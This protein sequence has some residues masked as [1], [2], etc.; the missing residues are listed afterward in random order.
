MGT[1]G[2]FGKY[3]EFLSWSAVG[4]SSGTQRFFHASHGAWRKKEQCV[5]HLIFLGPPPNPDTQLLLATTVPYDGNARSYFHESD[6]VATS[7]DQDL[8]ASYCYTATV[9]KALTHTVGDGVS[10]NFKIIF[11]R[12]D[13]VRGIAF[14]AGGAAGS[15]NGFAGSLRIPY[16]INVESIRATQ[17]SASLNGANVTSIT[18]VWPPYLKAVHLAQISHLTSIAT[19]F[20]KTLKYLELSATTSLGPSINALLADCDNMEILNLGS[21]VYSETGV[22]GSIFLGAINLAISHMTNIKVFNIGGATTMTNITFSNFTGVRRFQ[23]IAA[24]AMN[25]TTL[26]AIFNDVFISPV[27][28]FFNGRSSNLVWARSFTNADFAATLTDFYFHANQITGTITLTNPKPSLLNFMMGDNGASFADALKN[29][30]S[31]VDLSGLTNALLI[32]I[33]NC[34]IVNLT[35]PVNTVCTILGLGGNNLSV[36]TNPSLVSQINAMT[37]LTALYL[38]SGSST[39]S[40][41]DNGQDSI[42]GFGNN[43]SVS[44][45]TSLTILY[46]NRAKLTGILTLP[47]SLS[48][49]VIRDNNLSDIAGAG[50]ALRTVQIVGNTLFN[51]NFNLTPNIVSL[52]IQDTAQTIIDLSG[53]TTIDN[54]LTVAIVNNPILTTLSF[55]AIAARCVFAINFTLS[56]SGNPL[57][58]TITNIENINYPQLNTGATRGFHAQG[59]ALNTDLKIGVNGWLPCQIQLQDNGMSQANV[60]LNI[61]NIY[62]NKTKW[63][64]SL[65]AKTLQIAGT[66]AAPSGIEQAP[67]GFVLGS[68]DGTPTS[69]KEQIYVLENNYAWAITN[70]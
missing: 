5:L 15:G 17:S 29:N 30:F 3:Q 45:L 66:N 38:H 48:V 2:F 9:S 26:K 63:S 25:Q 27:L 19:K 23:L 65:A 46:A 28:K 10:R 56:L 6:I 36:T 7:F 42:D 43:L 68:A 57:L 1:F 8:I 22:A 44:G 41:A 14:P 51:H 33:S 50:N 13:L 64:T 55:S 70:N 52:T 69:A 49:L 53:K 24:T 32:D 34:Q 4:R 54:Y 39:T 12:P 31:T 20:P 67:P 11:H 47:A 18:G 21:V 35:L 62:V 58:N 61:N 37:A 59:C 16:L 40:T 60:D